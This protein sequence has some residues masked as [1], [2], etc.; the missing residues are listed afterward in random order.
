[1]QALFLTLLCFLSV[2][3]HVAPESA[4]KQFT[5]EEGSFS[6]LMP[7]EPKTSVVFTEKREGGRLATHIV[8]ASDEE[9]NEYL[10]SWTEYEA[11]SLEQKASNLTFDKMRDALIGFKEGKLLSEANVEIE[12][13]PGRAFTFSVGGGQL[14]RVRFYFVGNRS[15]QVMTETRGDVSDADSFHNSFKLLGQ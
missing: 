7:G 9:M 12:G 3:P 1:M 10:V 4:L 11:Q 6:A 8:S 15:Y 14:A 5:S 13:H 2:W